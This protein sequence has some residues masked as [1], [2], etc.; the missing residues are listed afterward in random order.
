MLLCFDNKLLKDQ[1]VDKMLYFRTILVKYMGKELKYLLRVLG[2]GVGVIAIVI[3]AVIFLPNF[4][5]KTQQKIVNTEE[6]SHVIELLSKQGL[7]AEINTLTNYNLSTTTT[8][9][10]FS[11]DQ[12]KIVIEWVDKQ[13]VNEI[14]SQDLLYSRQLESAG[15]IRNDYGLSEPLNDGLDLISVIWS[16]EEVLLL[17]YNRDS[18]VDAEKILDSLKVEIGNVITSQVS[19]T[20]T[21]TVST[22]KKPTLVK[23]DGYVV[24]LFFPKKDSASCEDLG[25]IAIKIKD[26]DSELSL[27]PSVVK[28]IMQYPATELD[29]LGFKPVM[30]EN[31]RL[32]SYGYNY[33]NV[34]FNFNELIRASNVCPLS[35]VKKS[36]LQTLSSL[37]ASSNLQ[38]KSVEIQIDG[39][40]LK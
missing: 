21:T 22:I 32:L 17:T 25:S 34:V 36:L 39:Q 37:Q 35:A 18:L 23:S 8:Q 9:V 29:K 16:N 6:K 14:V 33:N 5:I 15:L 38:I 24:N 4:V 31:V 28:I 40:K 30:D 26:I 10:L 3:I 1:I 13:R 27:I 11:K 7:K 19:S 12:K 20:T 2:I